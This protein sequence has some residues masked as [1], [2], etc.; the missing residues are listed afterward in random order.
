MTPRFPKVALAIQ[1][2]RIGKVK[3]IVVHVTIEIQPRVKRDRI[4]AE[5]PADRGVVVPGAVVVY[6][7]SV[8]FSPCELEGVVA[9]RAA[10]VGAPKRLVRVLGLHRTVRIR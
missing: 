8:V 7:R 6:A 4:L 3:R 5:E 9:G 10:E 2:S 1:A